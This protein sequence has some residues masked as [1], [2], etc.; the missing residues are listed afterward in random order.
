MPSR[1]DLERL[2]GQEMP[3]VID[4]RMQDVVAACHSL[5]A[6]TAPPSSSPMLIQSLPDSKLRPFT[7]YFKMALCFGSMLISMVAISPKFP[8]TLTVKLTLHR[9]SITMIDT[10][11]L[12]GATINVSRKAI[13]MTPELYALFEEDAGTA[14]EQM[15]AFIISRA[16]YDVWIKATRSKILS[17]RAFVRCTKRQCSG[18]TG[19]SSFHQAA[20]VMLRA[21]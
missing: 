2:A 7:W 20:L 18:I 13:W 15:R 9:S 16:E 3:V 21:A 1:S 19:A 10:P 12:Y 14:S 11:N 6:L 4:K 17:I 5:L 8:V